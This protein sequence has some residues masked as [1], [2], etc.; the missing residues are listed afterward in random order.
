MRERECERERERER[1][2]EGERERESEKAREGQR[3]KVTEEGG[4]GGEEFQDVLSLKHFPNRTSARL[5]SELPLPK[6]IAGLEYDHD[7]Q[8]PTSFLVE[9]SEETT[10]SRYHFPRG[11]CIPFDVQSPMLKVP[12]PTSK[13]NFRF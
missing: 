1:E 6:G 13:G 4:E 9:L 11:R 12:N 5:E 10:V 3:E 2:R 7:W 8:K